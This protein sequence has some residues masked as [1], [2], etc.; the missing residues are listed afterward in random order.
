[1]L[2]KLANKLS[3]IEMRKEYDLRAVLFLRLDAEV[4][5]NAPWYKVVLQ[6]GVK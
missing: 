6:G 3:T 5:A 1:M 4:T 2:S